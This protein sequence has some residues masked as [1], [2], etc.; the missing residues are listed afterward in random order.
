MC[1]HHFARV[2]VTSSNSDVWNDATFGVKLLKSCKLLNLKLCLGWW[3]RVGGFMTKKASS[4]FSPSL[5]FYQKHFILLC[6]IGIQQIHI[7]KGCGSWI[8]KNGWFNLY[9][10]PATCTSASK[11][12]S[13]LYGRS[14]GHVLSKGDFETFYYLHFF[15]VLSSHSLVLHTLLFIRWFF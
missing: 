7:S 6:S 2:G 12:K 3:W 14:T 4:T 8:N 13:D 1:Y 10:R 5:V 15:V 9:F 11:I